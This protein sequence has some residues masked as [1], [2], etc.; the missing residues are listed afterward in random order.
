MVPFDLHIISKT[1]D[2]YIVGGSV[3]DLL[4][5]RTPNDYDIVVIGNPDKFAKKIAENTNGHLVNIGKPG[6]NIIRVIALDKI[7]DISAANGNSIEKDLKSRDFT[8]NALGYCLSSGKIIDYSDGIQDLAN[9]R[10]RMASENIFKKDPVRLIRAY[11][12]GASLNFKIEPKTVAAIKEHIRLIHHSA[13]ERIKTELFKLLQTSRSYSYISNMAE[14][15][16]LQTIFPELTQLKGCTQN[17]HHKYDVFEHT[18]NAFYHLELLL[19]KL[20][21]FISTISSQ[22]EFTMDKKKSALLKLAVLLH[23]IGKPDVK[24]IDRKQNVHFYHHDQ[25]GAEMIQNISQRLKFSN[26]ERRFLDFIIRNHM[27]PL[28]LFKS[29]QKKT[30]TRRGSTRFF[31]KCG[32]YTPDLLLHAVADMQGKS[33]TEKNDF[34]IRFAKNMIRDFFLNF[35]PKRSKSPLI[36]GHDL[37]NEFGLTPSPFFKT[38]LSRIEEA[39]LS[40]EITNKQEALNLAKKF[41]NSG[42]KTSKS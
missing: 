40:K 12:L 15:G 42:T 2:A 31:I 26:H 36:T 25:R 7:F 16:L 3:R 17:K 39:R 30:L 27:Q 23:D 32:K 20:D 35:E 41:L 1:D 9:H 28:F 18:L 37:I 21:R 4:L 38:I 5:G 33:D 10:I 29:H 8:I 34:F 13:G 11:R 24:I 14:T 19:N 22:I 6:K